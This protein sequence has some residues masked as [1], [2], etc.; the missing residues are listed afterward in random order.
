M[1]EPTQPTTTLTGENE[2]GGLCLQVFSTLLRIQT[3]M[4]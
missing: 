4:W 3:T 1:E 2:A